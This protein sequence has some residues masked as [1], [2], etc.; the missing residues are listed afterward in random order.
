MP[1]QIQ[2]PKCQAN[3]TLPKLPP[4]TATLHC[5]RCNSMF[6]PAEAVKPAEANLSDQLQPLGSASGFGPL[7]AADPFSQPLGAGL[8]PVQP[9]QNR[10]PFAAL[11]AA[12]LQPQAPSPAA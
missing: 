8:Q 4:A 10:D 1:V 3:Y 11:Q 2:C 9:M 7:P 5:K 12:P 6:H